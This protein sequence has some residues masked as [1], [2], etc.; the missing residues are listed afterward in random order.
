MGWWLYYFIAIYSTCNV[1]FPDLRSLTYEQRLGESDICHCD[2]AEKTIEILRLVKEI[3][4]SSSTLKTSENWRRTVVTIR[5]L[6]RADCSESLGQTTHHRNTSMQ[7]LWTASKSLWQQ[8]RKEWNSKL[9]WTVNLQ[10]VAADWFIVYRETRQELCQVQR[11][12]VNTQKTSDT[13]AT[14]YWLSRSCRANN[15]PLEPLAATVDYCLGRLSR[16]WFMST[17]AD[18]PFW[19]AS[20]QMN[21]AVIFVYFPS[22]LPTADVALESRRLDLVADPVISRLGNTADAVQK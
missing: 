12:V 16:R 8:L 10:V 22:Q 14:S 4:A 6:Q 2:A 7:Y 13:Q 5:S 20:V 9:R 1:W 3:P 17:T 19:Y 15:V 11:H 21:G 18:R